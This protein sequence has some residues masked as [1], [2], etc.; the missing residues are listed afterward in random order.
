MIDLRKTRPALPEEA[1]MMSDYT[2]ETLR[3]MREALRESSDGYYRDM[4]DSI[5]PEFYLD[6]NE[7]GEKGDP[8]TLDAG[9]M[10]AEA[11]GWRSSLL[12]C[13]LVDGLED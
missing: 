11:R 4:M 3:M 12:T 7:G 6:D 13:E 9:D 1:G 8:L 10:I 5:S 2:C